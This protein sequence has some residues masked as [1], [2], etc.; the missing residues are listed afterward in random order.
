LAGLLKYRGT[1]RQKKLRGDAVRRVSCLIPKGD[2]KAKYGRK[3]G[4]RNSQNQD[5]RIVALPE[6]VTRGGR[7]EAKLK[8]NLSFSKSK[9]GRQRFFAR[10]PS[11]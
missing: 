6:I 5:G 11:R 3:F 9:S 7:K 2:M 8:K 1:A 4:I 10:G